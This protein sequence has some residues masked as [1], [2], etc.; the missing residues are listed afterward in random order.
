[1]PSY[2]RLYRVFPWLEDAAPGEPGH[3]L[4]VPRPQGHGRVDNPDHYLA[5]YASDDPDGAI[6][7]AFGNHSL[8]TTD[9]LRGQPSL[10]RSRRA[11]AVIDASAATVA[12]LD[13][14]A[15]LLERELRPSQV[16][17]RTRE[18]TQGWA[19]RLFREGRWAGVRWWS[20]YDPGWGSFGLWDVA[21]LHVLDV[22][23]LDDARA[24]VQGV[25]ARMCRVWE[26]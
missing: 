7:E 24:R 10:P 20:Y 12:D 1:M 16:V 5:L 11:L 18:V 15:T 9:L 25:A 21:A 22:T 17:T 13:D 6:G 23:P 19:L 2:P 14:P 4:Y 3:P 26:D 8:W